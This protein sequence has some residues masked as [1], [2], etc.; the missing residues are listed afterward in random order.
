MFRHLRP[1]WAEIDLDKLAHNMK[2]IRRASQS[3]GIIAVVKADAYGH[4]AVDV[5]P[6][7]LE[8]GA[9]RLAVAVI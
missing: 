6:V 7:L 4:G 2:E 9:D 1:V 8:N 3:K 5:A